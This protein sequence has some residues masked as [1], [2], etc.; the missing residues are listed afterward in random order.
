MSVKIDPKVTQKYSLGPVKY[1]VANAANFLGN[2]HGIKTIGGWRK[3][4]QFRDHPT[5]HAIDV[6]VPNLSVGA[7]V[8]Q[9]AINNAQALG[10]S[11]LI[12]NHRVWNAK[13]GWHPYT[14][15][16]N[17]HTDHV[18]ITMW[19][20]GTGVPGGTVPTGGSDTVSDASS[21]GGSSDDAANCAWKV[22]FVAGDTCLATHVQVRQG[23][24]LLA[25][26]TGLVLGITGLVLLMVYGVMKSD[27]AGEAA[28]M[29]RV[30][31]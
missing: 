11:Y 19:E 2:R 7:A 16:S 10:V 30:V 17:P 1:W 3:T 31:R 27:T 18:H 4:D 15:T 8:A 28:Q 23:F 25:M 20:P 24:G 21:T 22:K 14:S 6:M 9:D 13:Q 12:F 29:A 5:G 26:T